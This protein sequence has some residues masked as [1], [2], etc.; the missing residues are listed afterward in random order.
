MKKK[1]KYN[2]RLWIYFA[3]IVFSI[4]LSTALIMTFV[5]YFLFQMGHLNKHNTNPLLPVTSLL[6]M[7][8]IIGTSISLF[9]A[10][11]I[12][13]P[14]TNFSNATDEVAKG[15]FDIRIDE[16]SPIEEIRDL[17]K[18]FNMMAHELSSIETLRNDFIVNVSHEFKTPIATIEGYATLLQDN[19]LSDTEHKEYSEMIIYSA[20]QLNTLSSNILSLSKLENQEIILEK[21][22]YRLD[23]QI[24]QAIMMLE[25]DWGSKDL[26]FNINLIK[27]EYFGNE[28]LLMQVWIN[29]I[30]NAI[31]FTSHG[32]SIHIDLSEKDSY[33]IFEISDTGI[34]I[35]DSII[36]HIFDK[37]YQ[38]DTTRKTDGNGLGLALVK[39]II[40]LSEGSITVKSKVKEGTI[41]IIKLP[42]GRDF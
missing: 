24:R 13:K 17:S 41:F 23:E 42:I 30:G 10:K 3:L 18:N 11:K 7:S 29:L 33:L 26:I 15:N 16:E 9:V 37:F 21:E 2:S 38:G 32:G 39:R 25:P 19:N 8:V 6:F 4:M 40:D 12:L 22:L 28:S 14:I 1:K 35:D 20:R 31:K 5:A 36:N 27:T 34:G